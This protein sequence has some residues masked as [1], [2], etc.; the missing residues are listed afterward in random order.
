M[1]NYILY[2]YIYIY[3]CITIQFQSCLFGP[4]PWKILAPPQTTYQTKVSGQ[5][6]PW[7]KSCEGKSCDGNWVY[8]ICDIH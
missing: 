5:P 6:N 3:N 2:I 8:M 4:N 1:Y 7:E